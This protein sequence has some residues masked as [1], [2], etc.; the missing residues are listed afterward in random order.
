[1]S[2]FNWPSIDVPVPLW[3]RIK[4]E[5]Y[6]PGLHSIME[7]TMTVEEFLQQIEMEGN[8]ILNGEE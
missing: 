6:A 7:G 3:Q 8:K 4:E 5:Y 2:G 1:L